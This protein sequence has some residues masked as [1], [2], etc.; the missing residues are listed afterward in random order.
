MND[1]DKII[2]V[3]VI[4]YIVKIIYIASFPGTQWRF[5]IYSVHVYSNLHLAKELEGSSSGNTPPCCEVL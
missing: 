1:N 3:V 2:Y 5:T 4:I